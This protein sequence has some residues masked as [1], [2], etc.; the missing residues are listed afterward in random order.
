MT[1]RIFWM[2][3]IH[4]NFLKPEG[5]GEFLAGVAEQSPDVV[6]IGGD[7][8]EAP[9]VEKYL[10]AIEAT[11][12][13]TYFVLGNHDFYGGSIERVRKAVGKQAAASNSLNYLTTG[14]GASLG[15]DGVAELAEGVGL[16]GHDGWADGRLGDYAGSQVMLNDY[17][18]IMELAG[19]DK[20][21]R[22]PLL[23]QL[24][25]EAADHFRRV[26]PIAFER[27]GRVLLLTHVPPMREACW[28]EGRTSND[29]WVPH[30][31]CHAVGQALLE[32]M[33]QFPDRQLTVLCGH[34]HGRG[35]VRPLENLEILTGAAEYRAPA[36][37]KV[38]EF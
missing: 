16:V 19:V 10:R 25:D 27:F 31:A 30:F 36:V 26:L 34:T 5:V 38:F 17:R 11:E 6:L 7:I 28:H 14:A 4:L 13:P 18:L 12:C 33:P 15:D 23:N 21:R 37:E 35:E 3:D 20:A 32:I 2:T 1:K 24:G 22:L 8:A 29:E 9:T